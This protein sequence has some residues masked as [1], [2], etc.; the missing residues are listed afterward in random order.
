MAYCLQQG[1]LWVPCGLVY[2]L[3][4]YVVCTQPG[5]TTLLLH[6]DFG[7]SSIIPRCYGL[8]HLHFYPVVQQKLVLESRASTQEQKENILSPTQHREKIVTPWAFFHSVTPV[9]HPR[10]LALLGVTVHTHLP[11]SPSGISNT[12][13][14]SWSIVPPKGL[15]K[16]LV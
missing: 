4:G 15:Y 1:G 7:S 13:T 6:S 11:L 10:G 12:V 14:K 2:L 16:L 5:S 3:V 8:S 9:Y